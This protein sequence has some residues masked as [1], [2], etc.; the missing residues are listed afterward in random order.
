[1]RYRPIDWESTPKG[2]NIKQEAQFGLYHYAR[3]LG[4]AVG[5][6]R[7]EQQTLTGGEMKKVCQIH[8]DKPT[9]QA[10]S[11]SDLAHLENLRRNLERRLEIAQARGD[12]DLVTLLHRESRALAIL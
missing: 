2:I 6:P 4:Q 1:M 10:P 12:E 8:R 3:P 5:K 7:I 11:P 9:T